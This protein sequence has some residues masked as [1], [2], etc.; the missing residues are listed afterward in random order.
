VSYR[1]REFGVRMSLGATALQIR[2]LMLRDG[3]RPVLEGL[4]LGIWGGVAARFIIRSYTDVDIAVLDPWMLAVTPIPITLAAVAA[5]YLP[6]TRAG[7]V[8]PATALRY[9]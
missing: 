7:R 1:K 5:C 9:E 6:A 2:S 3:A 8:D 4:V